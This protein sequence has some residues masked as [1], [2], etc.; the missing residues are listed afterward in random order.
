MELTRRDFLK[1]GG[2]VFGG[3]AVCGLAGCIAPGPGQE[4]ENSPTASTRASEGSR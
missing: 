2:G 3:A 4:E 1:V